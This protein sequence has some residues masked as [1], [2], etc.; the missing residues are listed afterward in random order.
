MNTPINTPMKKR[1]FLKLAAISGVGASLPVW[2]QESPERWV[3]RLNWS[4]V[5]FRNG[6][7]DVFIDPIFTDIWGGSNR[8]PLVDIDRS[9]SRKYVLLTH[10]HGDHFDVTGLKSVL[11]EKDWII[12]AANQATNIASRGFQVLPVEPY[13]PITR[14]GFTMIPVP[15]SDGLGDEQVS[16]VVLFNGQRYLHCGDTIWHGKWRSYGAVYGPFDVVFMPVN[17]AI[18]ADEPASEIPL[19]LTPK[20][21]VDAAILLGAKQLVPTHYGFHV[22]GS[23][24]EVNEPLIQLKTLAD[25]R[26]VVV[27]WLKPG[28]RL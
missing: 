11:G 17:G 15:A 5:Q 9:A 14:R 21:A 26:Q 25:S 8:Y 22:P 1:T 13:Q 20:E 18:Q 27:N 7:T 4:G 10:T 6:S 3:R 12:C 24:E 19:S 28:E 16:W 23:Y 2:P